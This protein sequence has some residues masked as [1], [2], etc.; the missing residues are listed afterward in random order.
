LEVWK[1]GG[2]GFTSSTTGSALNRIAAVTD[3]ETAGTE[4][5]L[6]EIGQLILTT[7]RDRSRGRESPHYHTYDFS[8]T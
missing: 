1:F 8:G 5:Y 6:H 2:K 4:F 7:N 3:P